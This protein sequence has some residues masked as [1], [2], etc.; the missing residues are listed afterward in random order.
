MECANCPSKPAYVCGDCYSFAYCSEECQKADWIVHKQECALIGPRAKKVKKPTTGTVEK[1][2]GK[3]T[4]STHP[5]LTFTNSVK[6]ANP[7]GKKFDS[8]SSY[9]NDAKHTATTHQTV[10]EWIERPTDDIDKMTILRRIVFYPGKKFFANYVEDDSGYKLLEENL[11]KLASFYEWEN[12]VVPPVGVI[13]RVFSDNV[14][15]GMLSLLETPGRLYSAIIFNSNRRQRPVEMRVLQRMEGSRFHLVP[16]ENKHS[17]KERD[18][19]VEHITE[20]TNQY[21][22]DYIINWEIVKDQ[23]PAANPFIIDFPFVR[24]LKITFE[25]YDQAIAAGRLIVVGCAV[26]ERRSPLVLMLY[27]IYRGFS[28]EDAYNNLLYLNNLGREII[29]YNKTVQIYNFSDWDEFPNEKSTIQKWTQITANEIIK[30]PEEYRRLTLL[31][32][33]QQQRK[34]DLSE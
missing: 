14:L 25:L 8:E 31:K 6:F 16:S 12:G 24:S 34:M 10:L 2:A 26:C 27:L 15:N 4:A 17:D 7:P 21:H 22:P 9:V 32:Q 33:Q 1:T 13:H 20:K 11:P 28:L 30:T 18:F 3:K 19:F 5:H 29:P 23:S